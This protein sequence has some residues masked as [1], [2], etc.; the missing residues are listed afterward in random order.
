MKMK[1]IIRFIA[2]L[3]LVWSCAGHVELPG[4]ISDGMVL[5]RDGSACLWGKAVPGRTVTIKTSWNGETYRVRPDADSLWKVSVATTEAGGPY[6][7]SFRQ[8]CEKTVVSD[9]L[10]GEVWICSGQSNMQMP[11]MGYQS[12]PVEGSLE[13]LLEAPSHRLVR[14]M[15]TPRRALDGP[16]EDVP[17]SWSHASIAS[18]SEFSALGWFFSARLSDALGVPVGIIEADWGGTRIEAWMSRERSAK[19]FPEVG[20]MDGPN[21]LAVL[22]NSMIWPLRNYT[23]R[24]FLWYQ[25]ESNKEH[26]EVY[27]GLMAEMV[28]EWRTA[29]GGGEA[30][31]FYYA[32]LAPY[33][34]CNP[35][36]SSR[37]G[38]LTL[39]LLWEA[40]TKALS[41]IP[42]S[43]MAPTNDLGD[44][45]FIHPSRKKEVADRLVMLA[46]H[47]TYGDAGGI[48][49]GA[50][51]SWHAPI[52]KGVMF[53]GN[54][55]TV[56]FDSPGTLC[57][58]DPLDDVPLKGFEIAG[59]DRKFYPADA[60]IRKDG[61]YRFSRDVVVSSPRV[62]RPVAVRYSF[63]NLPDGNLTNVLGIPAVPF[64][65][66]DWP[67]LP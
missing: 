6:S 51:V 15:K 39:P 16:Q 49:D 36:D 25:G 44:P 22:Y 38:D 65:T 53:S 60:H 14:V 29:F 17:A 4:P 23:V 56:S 12:Q 33:D 57:P 2:P 59:A 9:V 19:A 11:V 48:E 64:R 50:T 13:A 54:E 35:F 24:G 58:L 55:A 27:A 46:L 5:Q 28:D 8:G 63:H 62:P 61:F 41:L 10:L 37:Y 31:P 32:M 30:M 40:Q 7:V 20:E 26:S 47:D 43:G 3:F 21:A 52:Y 34:Y 1:N 67:V 45:H 66:D 42:N 18:V